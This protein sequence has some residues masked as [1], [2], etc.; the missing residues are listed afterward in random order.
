MSLFVYVL[1]KP[2]AT[3]EAEA[4]ADSEDTAKKVF[5]LGEALSLPVRVGLE[6][7]FVAPDTKLDHEYQAGH[8]HPPWLWSLVE[9]TRRIASLGPV[10]VGLSD[11]DLQ[12]AREAHNCDLCSGR[13]R[14]ALGQFNM[15]QDA[16]PLAELDCECKAEWKQALKITKET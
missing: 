4:L 5:A 11:E 12:P 7:C 3:S 16:G 15:S 6:P 10:H 14:K 9:V 8:Y 13:V 2:M 1:L